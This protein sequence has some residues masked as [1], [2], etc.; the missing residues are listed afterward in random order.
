[1][2]HPETIL[3]AL[4]VTQESPLSQRRR[5]QIWRLRRGYPQD[6]GDLHPL[7]A[8]INQDQLSVLA[9]AIRTN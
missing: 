8:Q 5:S 6:I 9:G 4:S 7:K 3:T 2:R 1:M